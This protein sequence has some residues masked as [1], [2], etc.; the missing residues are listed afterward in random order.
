MSGYEKAQDHYDSLMKGVH[1]LLIGHAA[2]LLACL[3]ALKDY[4]DH[5]NLK[6]IG[7]LILLFGGG[8]IA[9]VVLWILSLIGR[10]ELL[11][12]I[13]LQRSPRRLWSFITYWG[14]TIGAWISVVAFILAIAIVMH[15]F[16]SL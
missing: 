16:G 8:L 14:S 2:G 13:Q 12:A 4:F 3:T 15:W 6:G 9:T 1:Y 5:L 7:C 10:M 11:A